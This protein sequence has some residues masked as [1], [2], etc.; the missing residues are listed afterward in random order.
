MILLDIQQNCVNPI[1]KKTQQKVSILAALWKQIEELLNDLS[2]EPYIDDQVQIDEIWNI[3]NALIKTNKLKQEERELR[4][5]ILSDEITARCAVSYVGN[6]HFKGV[7]QKRI[8]NGRL[9]KA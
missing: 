3:C 8:C 2:Y 7:Y 6:K 5:N 9:G 1:P 4:K